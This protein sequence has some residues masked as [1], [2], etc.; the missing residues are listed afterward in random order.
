M[1]GE[2]PHNRK[3]STTLISVYDPSEDYT[4]PIIDIDEVTD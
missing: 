2:R 3:R 1:P 4:Q